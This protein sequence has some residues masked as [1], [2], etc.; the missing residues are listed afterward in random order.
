[1]QSDEIE[2]ALATALEVI[3]ADPAIGPL[4][5]IYVDNHEDV[6]PRRFAL[7]VYAEKKV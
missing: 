3:A 2:R 5:I 6:L 7:F 4:E 1:M